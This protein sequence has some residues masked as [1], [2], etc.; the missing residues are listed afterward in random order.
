MFTRIKQL[1]AAPVFADDE[2]KTRVAALLNTISL[3]GLFIVG[4]RG[5]ATFIFQPNPVPFVAFTVLGMA[6]AV[7]TLVVLR[8]GYV[9]LAG[10][11]SCLIGVGIAT[12]GMFY[13]GGIRRPVYNLYLLTIASGG[14]LLGGRAAIGFAALCIVI[15]L[16]LM[17][18]EI[19]GLLPPAT[20]AVTPQSAWAIQSMQCIGMAM[21]MYLASR[22]INEAFARYKQSNR[23]LQAIR[24]S[25]EQQVLERTAQLQRTNQELER[26]AQELAQA[27]DAALE[28]VRAKSEFLATMSHE[29]RTPMNGVI[30]M[31]GLLLD[32]DLTDEQQEY[33]DA[34]KH[35][36]EALLTI[37]NDILDF[38]KIEA[39]KFELEILDFNLHTTVEEVLDL[40]A[41]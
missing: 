24:A 17:L 16:G 9:R 10:L 18:G 7:G 33:A 23:E 34:V 12:T 1:L 32:T 35:S 19:F 40:L 30:G 11:V 13:F 4:L 14:L 28:A 38:S 36:G 20:L 22:N 27:R 15:G 29:I 2:E 21:L 5:L 8:F 31:T 3:A 37:I 41:F 6:V 26:Q 39:G 25:L